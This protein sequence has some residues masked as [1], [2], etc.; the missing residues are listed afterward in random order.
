MNYKYF[1]ETL[2]DVDIFVKVPRLYYN[3]HKTHFRF[4]VLKL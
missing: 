1:H 4:S 2:S 3:V